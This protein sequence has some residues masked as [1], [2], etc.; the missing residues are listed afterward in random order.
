MIDAQDRGLEHGNLAVII[1]YSAAGRHQGHQ[2]C[3]RTHIRPDTR[4][5]ESVC[6]AAYHSSS[7]DDASHGSSK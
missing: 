7:A 2:P 1:K 6:G 3:K 5:A 4:L